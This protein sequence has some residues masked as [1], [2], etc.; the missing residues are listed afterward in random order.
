MGI[1]FIIYSGLVLI[2][3][4][5]IFCILMV[6]GVFGILLLEIICIFEVCFCKL[7][8]NEV[9]FSFVMFFD[10]MVAIELIIL[11]FFLVLQLIIIILFRVFVLVDILR[12]MCVCVLI[13]IFLEVQLIQLNISIFL[14]FGICREYC[15]LKF[16]IVFILVF[17]IRI[18]ILISGFLFVFVICL[19][20]VCCVQV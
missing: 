9:V 11:C 13:S 12:L 2:E 8:I 20:R 14:F 5:L 1:L 10:L 19:V 4:E 17:F 7:F 3:I 16:V 18:F 15:L 6:E